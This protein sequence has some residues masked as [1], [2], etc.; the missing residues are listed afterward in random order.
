MKTYFTY[1][2]SR[3]SCFIC[4]N[5]KALKAF[6]WECSTSF[7]IQTSI[8][9]LKP[10]HVDRHFRLNKVTFQKYLPQKLL[11]NSD[12]HNMHLTCSKILFL[13]H[14][15]RPLIVVCQLQFNFFCLHCFLQ[16]SLNFPKTNFMPLSVLKPFSKVHLTKYIFSNDF[17]LGL[18]IWQM[19]KKWASFISLIE[20]CN[21]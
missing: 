4:I 18:N 7:P 16:N 2:T 20:Q 10:T 11:G 19:W 13:M 1:L 5:S 21:R 14:S 3:L 9:V 12:P 17:S 15:T 6:K 8:G